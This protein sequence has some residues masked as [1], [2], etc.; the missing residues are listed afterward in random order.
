MP[1]TKSHAL[2]GR[3]PW[4]RIAGRLMLEPVRRLYA[5]GI[6]ALVLWLS[7]LAIRYLI[8]TLMF[9]VP[10]PAQ[11]TG[12]P[13]RLTE[14]MLETRRTQWP[15]V[16]DNE[17]PRAPLAH[18]HRLDE[19]IEPDRFNSCTQ[20]GCHAP[21]PHARH[22]EVRAFLNMHATSLN[23]AVCHLQAGQRPLRTVWYDL[24]SGQPRPA[25]D[26]LWAYGWL[27]SEEG[28]QELANPTASTQ[29]KLV[30]LLRGA[31]R[32][33]DNVPALKQLAD[34]TAAVRYSSEAFQQLVE[35][36]RSTLPRHFRGE[37]GAKLTLLDPESQQ[38]VLAER[39]TEGAVQAYLRESQTA[40]PGR[41]QQ[42]LAAV[43]SNLRADMLHCTE[44]HTAA[45]GLLDFA[46][47]GY[48]PARIEALTHAVIFKMI[49]H[50]AA[51]QP[52]HLPSF[53]RPLESTPQRP[54]TQP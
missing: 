20:S 19:W 28:R 40:E 52:F 46:A 7:F 51:G 5:A 12:I 27:M 53:V 49:E 54:A 22:K 18:Y 37:Y 25:P 47:A 9:P 1:D 42:L 24:S 31:A 36:A 44:C 45:G 38:P 17:N 33:S 16:V 11:I 13:R 39:G 15:G 10:A 3:T 23:C 26:A 21:L 8:V 43:H 30:A 2:R 35:A 34:H 14:A 50:I 32:E 6:I 48:P 41:K 4:A 29:N